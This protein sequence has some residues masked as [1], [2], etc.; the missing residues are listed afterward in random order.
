M[1]P[2]TTSLHLLEL[3]S[4]CISYMT[5]SH[6]SWELHSYSAIVIQ[7]YNTTL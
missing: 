6:I 4:K 1:L 5:D 2:L 3:Q 7:L